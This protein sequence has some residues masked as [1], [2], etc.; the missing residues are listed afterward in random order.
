MRREE[1]RRGGGKKRKGRDGG[2]NG[3]Y[4]REWEGRDMAWDRTGREGKRNGERRGKW[5][6]YWYRESVFRNN[7]TLYK[8]RVRSTVPADTITIAT[9]NV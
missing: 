9:A 4:E 5:T 3:K 6:V 8:F 1:K 7:K 2:E